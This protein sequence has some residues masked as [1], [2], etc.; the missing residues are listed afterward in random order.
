MKDSELITKL[1]EIIGDMPH[2]LIACD[3]VLHVDTKK[4]NEAV[5]LINSRTKDGQYAEDDCF[6]ELMP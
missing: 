5:G 1:A 2:S 6:E 3:G 4:Y